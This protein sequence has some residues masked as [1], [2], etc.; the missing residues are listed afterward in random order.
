MKFD[1]LALSTLTEV[2]ALIRKRQV[3]PVELT[4]AML[5]RI[6]KIDPKLH[7]YATVTPDVALGQAKAAES[8]IG[9]AAGAGR[10]MEFPSV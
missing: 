10:S 4:E 6:E 5:A 2:S 9:Q 3:S 7:S 1:E 8:E